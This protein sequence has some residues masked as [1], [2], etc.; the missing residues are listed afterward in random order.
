MRLLY[1]TVV[2]SLVSMILIGSYLY[3]PAGMKTALVRPVTENIRDIGGAVNKG[4]AL[5]D[6]LRK[7]KT[8]IWQLLQIKKASASIH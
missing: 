1:V 4:D 2:A 8:D 7:Y 5:S 6:I 3:T